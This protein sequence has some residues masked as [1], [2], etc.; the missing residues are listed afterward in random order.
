MSNRRGNDGFLTL[1]LMVAGAAAVA[2]V[3]GRLAAGAACVVDGCTVGADPISG[4]VGALTGP[5]D[6]AW[7]APGLGGLLFWIIWVALLTAA[8]FGV[9]RVLRSAGAR[10]WFGGRGRT[11]QARHEKGLATAG[12]VRRF[13]SAAAVES[14]VWLRPDLERPSARDLAVRVG[15]ARRTEVWIPVE[16]S[17]VVSAPSRSSKSRHFVEPMLCEYPGAVLGT[18]VRTEMAARTV[19]ERRRCGPVAVFAPGGIQVA[20]EAGEA[21]G[22]A[23]LRWSL[24][25]GCED[26]ETAMRR[27]R[28]LAANGGKGTGDSGFWESHARLV[29]APLLHAAAISGEGVTALARWSRGP[30]QAR[31]AVQVMSDSP[32][33]APDWADTLEAEIT[34]DDRTVQ[35]IWKTVSSCV[36]EPLMDPRVRDAVCPRDGQDLDIDDFID[37]RGT[38]YIVGDANATSAPFVA[39]LIE[40]FYAVATARANRSEG[41]R[42]CPP[43]FLCLD[44]IAN[45]AVLP[46]L[47]QMMSAGGGS[48]VTTLV[49]EQSRHQLASRLGRDQAKALWDAATTKLVLG[50][51]MDSEKIGEV[52]EAAGERDVDRRTVSPG[53]GWGRS[54]WAETQ[55]KVLTSGQVHRLEK[56]TALLIKGS[57]PVTFVEGMTMEDRARRGPVSAVVDGHR[58]SLRPAEHEE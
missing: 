21:L 41:N 46:S 8:V 20:G 32:D 43:L 30:G 47:P 53:P 14:M 57:A 17:M 56:G 42:L 52:I 55:E 4:T 27:A 12:Q 39:A 35:N 28:A 24:T 44:E 26:P 36:S 10:S 3:A 31:E 13:F 18:S 34:G 7:R 54:S 38:L 2:A 11:G 23:V 15:T 6:Q 48:N 45:I 50:G 33:A 1:G 37:R 16:D 25:R 51:A 5:A 19:V 22:R 29:L 9:I 40:D 58:R 49:V